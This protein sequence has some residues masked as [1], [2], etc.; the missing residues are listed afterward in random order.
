M[1]MYIENTNLTFNPDLL[2]SIDVAESY[3]KTIDLSLNMGVYL[4][5]LA[6][7][8]LMENY[9]LSIDYFHTIYTL[10]EKLNISG[11]YDQELLLRME[12]NL[13]NS[14]SLKVIAED[15]FKSLSGYLEKNHQENIFGIISVGSFIEFMHL[16]IMIAGEYSEDN[17]TIKRISDQKL[18]FGNMI[19]YLKEYEDE[20]ISKTL[21]LIGPL[22]EFYNQ[23]VV[24][25]EKTTVT[26]TS[27]DKLVFG[28]KKKNILT[29]EEYTKLKNIISG[30]RNKIIG[31][32]IQ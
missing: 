4:S 22:D 17:V 8:T 9:R 25:S 16:A 5:D 31:S 12:K 15:A 24:N 2:H 14:D 13:R 7:I 23:I 1:F 29:K 30:I 6:Y 3:L 19:K 18:V 11:S 10:S 21:E 26:K 32:E 20:N 27:E 28:G